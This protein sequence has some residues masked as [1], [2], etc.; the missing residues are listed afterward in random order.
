MLPSKTV[1]LQPAWVES[2][3]VSAAITIT[4]LSVIPDNLYIYLRFFLNKS[5]ILL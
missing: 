1:S 5:D 4:G 2:V 3:R